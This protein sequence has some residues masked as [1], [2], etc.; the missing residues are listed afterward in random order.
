[1]ESHTQKFVA[2][3]LEQAHLTIH[4][5]RTCAED[6]TDNDERDLLQL[7]ALLLQYVERYGAGNLEEGG[8]YD[9]CVR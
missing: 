4:G 1:M 9:S 5:V 8:K 7:E 3:C 2:D 6:L